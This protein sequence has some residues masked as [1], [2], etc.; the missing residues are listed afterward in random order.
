MGLD[1]HILDLF[2]TDDL[3]NIDAQQLVVLILHPQPQGTDLA[4][5]AV[6][7]DHIHRFV[8]LFH[9]FFLP[10]RLF[11]YSTFV[12]IYQEDFPYC[13]FFTNLI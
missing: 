9:R 8:L 12:C 1:A 3:V 11:Y 2:D 5:G 10:V 7:G 13:Q 4:G 6:H